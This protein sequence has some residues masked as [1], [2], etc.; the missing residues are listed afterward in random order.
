M[1]QFGTPTSTNL[2]VPA[3][4]YSSLNFAANLKLVKAGF[5]S[6]G[7]LVSA[8]VVS[9]TT[10]HSRAAALGRLLLTS[11]HTIVRACT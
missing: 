8:V 2:L 4:S 7:L 3:Y 1:Y 11:T 10:T 9:H 5:S 6:D